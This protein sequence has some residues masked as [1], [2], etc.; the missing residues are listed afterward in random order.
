[1]QRPPRTLRPPEPPTGG[2]VAWRL[3]IAGAETEIA[4]NQRLGPPGFRGDV[5]ESTLPVRGSCPAGV[6]THGGQP[7]G[8][9][10]LE[11]AAQNLA[12]VAAASTASIEV[13]L[14]SDPRPGHWW[15]GT[16]P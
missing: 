12:S 1:M 9:V 13:A 10:E 11:R 8:R 3:G 5:S 15:W 6:A 14:P 16:A 7:F 2:G 4:E